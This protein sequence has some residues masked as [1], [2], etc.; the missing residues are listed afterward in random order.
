MRTTADRIAQAKATLA[1]A[2]P[3][4]Q[5]R[6]P[7]SLQSVPGAPL[8]APKP[9][10]ATP[11]APSYGFP[12]APAARPAAAP[13]AAAANPIMPSSPAVPPA[14]QAPGGSAI[15]NVINERAK[16]KSAR[17]SLL[18][19]LSGAISGAQSYDPVARRSAL[20]AER[21]VSG[22]RATLGTFDEEVTKAN[23]LLDNIE[24][25]I[26]QRTS[27]F[28]VTDPQQRR[29]LAS[30][31]API[32][33]ML[34]IAERG[35]AGAESRLAR[36]TGDIETILSDEE[37]RAGAPLDFLERELGITRDIKDTTAEEVKSEREAAIA[38]LIDQGVDDPM[39]IY[40]ALNFDEEGNRIGDISINEINEFMKAA[41]G[42]E[43]KRDRLELEKLEAEIANEK[44]PLKRELLQAQVA[45]EWAKSTGIQTVSGGSLQDVVASFTK[46]KGVSATSKQQVAKG[47]NIIKKLQDIAE[48]NPQG[49]F[50]GASPVRGAAAF[51]LPD[52]LTPSSTTGFKAEEAKIRQDLV[53]YI[54]GAA[55]TNLQA[56]D[57]DQI[58][59]RAGLT[60]AKNKQRIEQLYNTLI[61][62]LESQLVA[63][64]YST[65]LPRT[66]LFK[67][68]SL[69]DDF[70]SYIDE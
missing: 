61:G 70:E 9:A 42:N 4:P 10:A 24:D 17:E 2:T 44:D 58:I 55:Y 6:V 5:S 66:E 41:S 47:L 32:L 22:I 48:A 36:E 21:G 40:D 35:A 69:E 37:K 52:F 65:E 56:D 16:P 49:T 33:K 27:E 20:E 68:A 29:I 39:S 25:D 45:A 34:G 15:S 23:V 30:E 64:G 18:D 28:L 67:G 63:N 1:G 54:T 59:P 31:S 38:G 13:P 51:V 26:K 7:S 46:N 43:A 11:A 57:V 19:R 62:D 14:P 3:A 60:D 12:A 50:E 8:V 53:T